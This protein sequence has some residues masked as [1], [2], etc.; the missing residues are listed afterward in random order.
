MQGKKDAGRKFYQLL[1]K[2]LRHIGL[3]HSISDHGVFIW[4]QVE[5]KMFIALATYDCIFVCGDRQQFLDLKS[6][7]EAL[8]VVTLQEG[9]NLWFLNLRIIQI[10]VGIIIDQTD[11][12]VE[13]VLDPYF[14]DR[15]TTELRS[16][17]SPFPTDSSF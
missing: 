14:Q 4:K 6:K 5:S 2:Y 15:D 3:I 10:P 17:T 8:F 7:M 9:A 12:I 13:N 1:Y 11:H 16:I